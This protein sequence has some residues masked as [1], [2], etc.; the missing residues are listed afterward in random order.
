MFTTLCLIAALQAAPP[1]AKAP[2]NIP[3]KQAEQSDAAWRRLSLAEQNAVEK[4]AKS[5]YTGPVPGLWSFVIEDEYQRLSTGNGNT[6]R[7]DQLNADDVPRV[8][9]LLTDARYPDTTK[10]F[11]AIRLTLL[12]SALQ[13][14]LA[15][16]PGSIFMVDAQVLQVADDGLRVQPLGFYGRKGAKLT[17]AV[18]L[19]GHPDQETVVDKD[20]LS[21]GVAIQV[22]PDGRYRYNSVGKGV[23]AIEAYKFVKLLDIP[24][25]TVSRSTLKPLTPQELA[26]YLFDNNISSLPKW[27]C[28][29]YTIKPG[30]LEESYTTQNGGGITVKKHVTK[31]AVPA[32]YGWRWKRTD[33]KITFE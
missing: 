23:I 4:F 6:T 30:E 21:N 12:E 22:K 13:K 5:C 7:M 27:E 20:L 25:P 31:P 15:A 2:P 18:F 24:Q 1:D 11:G 33:I 28:V 14:E 17:E 9:N 10:C 3:P 19:R 29:R 32:V 26:Q 16:N 8:Y